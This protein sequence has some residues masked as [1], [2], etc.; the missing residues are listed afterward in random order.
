M[1]RAILTKLIFGLDAAQVQADLR[2]LEAHKIVANQRLGTLEDRALDLELNKA[3][4]SVVSYN[5]GQ[6][7]IRMNGLADRL[8]NRPTMADL[9]QAKIDLGVRLDKLEAT[10]LPA[11]DATDI[12]PLAKKVRAPRKPKGDQ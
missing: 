7:Q 8:D 2:N 10:L 12:T 9:S 3:D 5:T 11:K 6:C 4:K 1:I